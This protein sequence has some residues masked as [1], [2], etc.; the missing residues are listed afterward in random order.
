MLPTL[1]PDGANTFLLSL[2]DFFNPRGD[3]IKFKFY[4]NCMSKA[5]RLIF[6]KAF[7]V[8]AFMKINALGVTGLTQSSVGT[9]CR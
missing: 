8:L 6:H 4:T 2:H 3:V 9:K 7:L 5:E 1:R